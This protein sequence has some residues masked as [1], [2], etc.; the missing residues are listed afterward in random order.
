MTDQPLKPFSPP[1]FAHFPS[2]SISSSTLVS[3]VLYLIFAFWIIYTLVA[4]YHWLRY[5]HASWVAV[6]AIATHLIVSLALIGYA[7]SSTFS[8]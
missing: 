3:W 5:S 1:N 7:L 2:I 6:P 4:I 8:L